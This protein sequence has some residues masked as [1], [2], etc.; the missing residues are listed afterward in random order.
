MDSVWGD[1]EP[2][3]FYSVGAKD[4]FLWV[5]CNSMAA[6]NVEPFDCLMEALF[7][8]ICPEQGIIDAFCLVGD[9]GDY[10]IIPPSVAIARCNVT[11]G[12]CFVTISAPRCDEG[13]EV[14]VLDA[15]GD[16]VIAIP[17]V[18]D[19]L[20]FTM[21][22]KSR[23]VERG[24]RVMCF[25]FRMGIEGLKV[26]C[27]TWFPIL[28]CTDHHSVTPRNGFAYRHGLENTQT[29]VLIKACFH[30]MLPMKWDGYGCVV[31]HRF[32]CR[33]NHKLEWRTLHERKRLVVTRI[34]C[35]GFVV[36]QEILL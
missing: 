18:E 34:E 25:P 11:L 29:D 31:S 28:L 32:G 12:C 4:K 24:G 3:K 15:N 9:F 20:L 36:V 14:A 7:Q 10:F 26:D 6:T 17:C 19:S 33:V 16:A 27:P 8:G 22:D 13:C 23:L 30:F 21:W 35:A 2:G 1:F 5:E